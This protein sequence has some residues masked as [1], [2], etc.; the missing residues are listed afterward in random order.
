MADLRGRRVLIVDDDEAQREVV[1][2][3]LELEG[4]EVLSAATAEE[5]VE[6]LRQAPDVLLM[7]LHGV[8]TEELLGAV[9]QTP[10]APSL[11]VL[12]GDMRLSQHAQRM[13]ADCWLG[14]P[15]ELEDLLKEVGRLIRARPSG[16]PAPA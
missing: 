5:A 15:Y 9:R 4:I 2:E 14:K 10:N 8:A 11:L 12:S 1:G 6:L 7:D 16:H 3:I 13:H